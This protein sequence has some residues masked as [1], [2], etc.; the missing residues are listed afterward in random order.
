MLLWQPCARMD[1]G[2]VACGQVFPARDSETHPRGGARSSQVVAGRSGASGL[3]LARLAR[4]QRKFKTAGCRL[5]LLRLE[6]RGLIDLPPAR[7]RVRFGAPSFA[8]TQLNVPSKLE[9]TLQ[10]VRGLKLI[11][12]T[13][14]DRALDRQWKKLVATHHYLGYRPLC[15][16]QVRYLI[17][18]EHRYLGALGFSAAALYLKARERWIGWSHAARQYHLPTV[19][20]NSR[21]VIARGVRVLKKSGFQSVGAGAKAFAT[22]LGPSVWL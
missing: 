4:C 12:V 7:R 18:F 22:G 11:L 8:Q 13:S 5:A 9:G 14:K 6:R 1:N 2:V 15:G 10:E 16:A 17:A 3:R 19:V 21:F 20:A